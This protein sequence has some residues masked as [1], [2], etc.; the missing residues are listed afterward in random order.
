MKKRL[1]S[2]ALAAAMILT[3]TPFAFA[4]SG[5]NTRADS[6][7]DAAGAPIRLSLQEAVHIMQTTGNRAQTAEIN[8][9]SDK[10]V[11]EGYSETVNTIR[12]TLDKL[13]SIQ[14]QINMLPHVPGI[15]QDQIASANSAYW[16][17]VTQAQDGGA[18][19]VNEKVMKLRRDFAKGQVE[20]NYQA[21]M[22][23]IEYTTVQVYYG[24]LL[25][26]D[27]LKIAQDNVKAQQDIL[28]DAQAQFSVG[29]AAKKD[30]LAAQSA[31]ESAKSDLQA[32]ETKLD[33]AKMSFNF[34][35]D[36]PVL[37]E[38]VYTD[39]LTQI[40]GPAISL[41]DAIK[42]A[43][44][45]RNEVKGAGF[46]KDVHKILLDTLQFQYPSNSATYL[47]QKVAYMNAE[48]TA[49]DAPK[50]IEIDIRSR[51]A[52]LSD[53]KKAIASA[54]ATKKYAEEGYRLTK[55]SYEAGMCTLSEVQAMQVTAYKA[56]L[57]VAAAKSAYDL[58]VYDFNYATA[59]GTSRLPL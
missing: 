27:N 52:K 35:L 47:N 28:K 44:Q 57:G 23:G 13:D 4:D 15:T 1:I 54:E 29:M 18:T 56:S 46:A 51:Y 42:S 8:R 21:E 10:A 53:L 20:S 59:V 17:G 3:A 50:Q 41:D 39:Q 26:Q 55:L 49:K 34:L 19:A 38:V 48:K 30:V 14:A 45:N 33:T 32:S 24:V 6:T 5:A 11:A 40:T 25:G 7:A 9:Q 36:Y 22:N 37:Q 31:L 43:Q 58:A 12:T 16:A 2:A